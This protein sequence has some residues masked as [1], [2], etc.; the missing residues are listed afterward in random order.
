MCKT[1]GEIVKRDE[2]VGVFSVDTFMHIMW[3]SPQWLS[4]VCRK[5]L[6]QVNWDRLDQFPYAILCHSFLLSFYVCFN[7]EVSKHMKLHLMM[8]MRALVRY[9]WMQISD[10]LS[11]CMM[12]FANELRLREWVELYQ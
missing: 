2:N 5:F 9:N 1:R 4:T 12:C 11:L 3:V 8:F 7:S 6:S 10:G